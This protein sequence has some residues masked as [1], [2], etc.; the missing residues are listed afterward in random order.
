MYKTLL[1]ALCLFSLVC[2]APARAEEANKKTLYLS[3]AFGLSITDPIDWSQG[4][5]LTGKIK[6]EKQTSDFA[7]ALGLNLSPHFAAEFEFS[8]RVTDYQEINVKYVGTASA[9]G[10]DQVWAGLLNG[11]IN[12]MPQHKLCPYLTVGAGMAVH[13]LT[14]DAVP[15]LGVNGV[16][17]THVVAA[18]QYGAGV[19]YRLGPQSQLW[20]GYR[21]FVTDRPGI[22]GSEFEYTAREVRLGLRRS[23]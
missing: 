2:A 16:S 6:M 10:E 5:S 12:L 15:A 11:Y 22:Q 14:F 3:G 18:F 13:D 4:R 23:F 19:N 9:H 8:Y 21:R 7:A 1:T 17:D 20:L